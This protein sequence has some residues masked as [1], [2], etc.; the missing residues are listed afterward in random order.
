[1]VAVAYG[2]YEMSLVCIV[3]LANTVINEHI[4]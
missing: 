4:P 3:Q 1:M 2:G